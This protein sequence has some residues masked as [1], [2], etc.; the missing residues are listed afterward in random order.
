[1][2]KSGVEGQ[3]VRLSVLE[4]FPALKEIPKSAFPQHVLIIPDGNRRFARSL[5]EESIFG[6]RKGVEVLQS[7]LRD[8]REL[9]IQTVTVW[10]FS[11]DNWQRSEEELGALMGLFEQ[12]IKANLPE[13]MQYNTRFVHLGRK[14]RLP[15]SLQEAIRKAE[16]ETTEN[17]GQ[18][19]C[20]AIDF[21]GMDQEIRMMEKLRMMKEDQPLT[22]EIVEGLRDGDGTIPS[23]DLIIRTS[24]E[25][26]TS[27]IGWLNGAN[28]ELYFTRKF[29][30]DMTTKDIVDALVDFSRRHRRLGA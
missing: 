26:R 24:G 2:E 18:T 13:L 29:F 1:M 8:L 3:P 19:L 5:S 14:D 10:G 27:D 17:M 21:G 6:H 28:T 4:R 9:P 16:L 22:R 25:M 20:L 11:A 15:E 23:A 7:I 30:P 12:A